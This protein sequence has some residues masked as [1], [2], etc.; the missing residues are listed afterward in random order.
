MDN[1]KQIKGM[2]NPY[3]KLKL[4]ENKDVRV[5]AMKEVAKFF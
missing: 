1:I 5:E 2:T 4:V 3:K